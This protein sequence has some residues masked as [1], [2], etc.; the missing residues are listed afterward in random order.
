MKSAAH[1]AAGSCAWVINCV[2]CYDLLNGHP[3]GPEHQS[4]SE[5]SSVAKQAEPSNINLVKDKIKRVN[6]IKKEEQVIELASERKL[7]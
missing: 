7:E 4:S 2:I 3:V 1:A 6:K 5:S